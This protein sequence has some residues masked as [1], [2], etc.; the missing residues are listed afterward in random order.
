L[1]FLELVQRKMVNVRTR[2]VVTDFKGGWYPTILKLYEIYLERALLPDGDPLQSNGYTFQNLYPFLSKYNAFF[3]RFVD[4]L[5]SATI[6]LRRGGLLIRNS[7]FTK[8]KHW[9]KRGVNVA[10]GTTGNDLRGNSLLQFFGD[11]GSKFSIIQEILAPPPPP[12]QLY[13]ETTEGVLGSL[14]TGGRNI[15]GY[16]ELSEYGID[17]K[18]I[19]FYPSY[20]YGGSIPIGLENLLEGIDYDV[21]QL[22]EDWTRISD[23]GPLYANNFSMTLTGLADDAD[24]QYRAF[25]KSLATGYTG[26]TRLIHTPIV[27]PTPSLTTSTPD[28]E[29]YYSIILTGGQNIVR[30]ADVQYYAM[31][32]R[33]WNGFNWGAWQYSPSSPSAGPLLGSSGWTRTITGL[34]ASTIYQFRAYMMVDNV[35]YYGNILEAT[36]DAPPSVIPEVDTGLAGLTSTTTMLINNNE[37]IDN[38][39]P[40]TIVEYGILYAYTPSLAQPSTLVWSSPLPTGIYKNSSTTGYPGEGSVWSRTLTSL[41]SNTTVYYRAF[42]RNTAFASG[43]GYGTIKN[44]R[45]ATPPVTTF[46]VRLDMLWTGTDTPASGFGGVV[47]L[48]NGS[49]VRD[50]QTISG[51]QKELQVNLTGDVGTTYSID[52]SAVYG[53]DGGGAFEPRSRYRI[54]PSSLWTYSPVQYNVTDA[55]D[56]SD[57]EF[58]EEY[59]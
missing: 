52:M 23:N 7:I 10:S 15:I 37:V 2:K 29:N 57:W 28:G 12:T 55:G 56:S 9:Y 19:N 36:T 48:M 50:H 41:P 13:V 49:V 11:D 42:A 24:Y 25:V 31:Q 17:Y 1:E 27:L 20:P 5:L 4:Q 35:A 32:Y 43:V 38:G 46:V 39:T 8:Q 18:R 33:A 3:Q 26:N 53:N 22:A 30:Y 59:I 44:K 6:I 58:E 16:D 40:A 21:E 34:Q 14:T 45:T 47:R 54:P 51:I